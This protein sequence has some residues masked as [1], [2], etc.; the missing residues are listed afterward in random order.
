M[1]SFVP[2]YYS[3]F[4][5]TAER[6]EHNCCIGWEIDIDEDSLSGYRQVK[7]EMGERLRD[8]RDDVIENV[9][10]TETAEAEIYPREELD[11]IYVQLL[12]DLL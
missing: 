8:E 9:R 3:K 2:D 11:L 10:K 5:C 4:R 7:G 1:E 12:L 6:C